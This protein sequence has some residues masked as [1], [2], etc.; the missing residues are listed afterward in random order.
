MERGKRGEK[1]KK[2]KVVAMLS[3]SRTCTETCRKEDEEC[4]QRFKDCRLSI[5]SEDKEDL[6]AYDKSTNEFGLKA[7]E[8]TLEENTEYGEVSRAL[9]ITIR[10]ELEADPFDPKRADLIEKV[11]RDGNTWVRPMASA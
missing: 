9:I 5:L 4:L 7:S 11:K 1:K 10:S 3:W 8:R 6:K 2:K